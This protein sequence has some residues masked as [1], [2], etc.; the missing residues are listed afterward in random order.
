MRTNIIFQRDKNNG[1]R[2]EYHMKAALVYTSTTPELIE[3]VEREVN[4][5]IGE[6]VDIISLENPDILAQIREAG[7][8]PPRRQRI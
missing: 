2:R 8:L 3:L 5:Q 1:E 4:A 7:M 6:D